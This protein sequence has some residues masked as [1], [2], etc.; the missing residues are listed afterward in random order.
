M[1][2]TLPFE[3]GYL[4]KIITN[5]NHSDISNNLYLDVGQNY[6]QSGYGNITTSSYSNGI[7]DENFYHPIGFIESKSLVVVEVMVKKKESTNGLLQ[8]QGMSFSTTS[9][10]KEYREICRAT[11]EVNTFIRNFEKVL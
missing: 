2:S 4:Y 6:Y 7:A 8:M 1:D 5:P 10:E 3:Y 11:I 9:L